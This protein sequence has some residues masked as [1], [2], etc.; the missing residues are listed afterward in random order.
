[1]LDTDGVAVAGRVSVRGDDFG[2][3]SLAQV[4]QSA[5]DTVVNVLQKL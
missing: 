2:E 4:M 1:M 3:Q 5:R